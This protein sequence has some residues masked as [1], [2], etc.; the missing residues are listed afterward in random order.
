MPPRFSSF[1][2][3]WQWFE[4]GGDLVSLAQ[5][6][7]DML[8]GR[9]Q[10][11]FFHVRMLDGAVLDAAR[12]VLDALAEIADPSALQPMDPEHLHVSILPVGFQVIAKRRDDELLPREVDGIAS[13]ASKIVK[14]VKRGRVRVGPVN[15]FPDALILEVRDDDG[16]LAALRQALAWELGREELGT[17]AMP[18]LP[19][20]TI[21]WFESAAVTSE[22]RRRL[23]QLRAQPPVET[24]I[25]RLELARWWFTGLEETEPPELDVVREYALKR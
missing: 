9:A 19:H 1:D 24:E 8:A 17:A 13:R 15:V 23:P 16:T 2:E 25:R 21:A 12:D 18:F 4:A 10:V 14:G 7:S 11:L 3:A 22:L 6:R 5:Q 20:I